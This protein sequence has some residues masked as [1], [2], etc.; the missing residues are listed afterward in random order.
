MA[1]R[2]NPRLLTQQFE[3]HEFEKTNTWAKPS[4][5]EPILI[6]KVRIDETPIADNIS[7]TMQQA[8]Q[9]NSPS[10]VMREQIGRQ[11]PAGV[12]VGIEKYSDYAIDS[13][14]QVICV[15]INLLYQP[16]ERKSFSYKHQTF[17]STKYKISY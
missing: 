15:V 11:I 8:L 6:K 7:R 12:A 9:I 13:V 3:Y 16:L 14:E 17:N 1:L 5:K 2:I 10:R 4:Y